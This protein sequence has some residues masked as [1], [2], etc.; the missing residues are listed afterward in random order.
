M[1]D[2]PG[3]TCRRRCGNMAAVAR[4]ERG[5]WGAR[6]ATALVVAVV[7]VVSTLPACDTQAT[8][9]GS[10]AVGRD[11]GAAG[12]GSGAAPRESEAVPSPGCE[13]PSSP[14][15]V[16]Q[17]RT[18]ETDGALRW[19]LVT[20]PSGPDG[21]LPLVLDF[22]GLSEGAELHSRTSGFSALAEEEGFV[23][24]YPQGTGA[25]P[26]WSVDAGGDNADARF[27]DALLSE[28]GR[29]LCIDLTRVYATGL[30]NGALL[31]SVLGC[32]RAATFAAIAPV[33]GIS[34]PQGCEPATPVPVVSYHGTADPILLF[35]GGVGSVLVELVNGRPVT[36]TEL[37]PAD[38]EGAGY[39]AAAE[40]WAVA[41]GCDGH[42]DEPMGESVL[43]RAYDCPEGA[44]TELW[45]VVGG[46]HSWPGSETFTGP[47]AGIF[48]PTT[49][50][51]DASRLTW[52]FFARHRRLPP[53]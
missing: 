49:D 14:P 33:A 21:P 5:R 25:L 44:D 32:S 28:L 35:N 10:G 1:T 29:I 36:P 9:E 39:P 7:V 51:I 53:T 18:L 15:V 38:L 41:N 23:V 17:K 13:L 3:G 6:T 22:H 52:E 4:R 20:V 43:H 27:V 24:A 12:R 30:S 37:P 42:T 31:T 48:G 26:G 46:G 50:E 16:E 47:L 8:P 40:A 11:S 2:G 19:Y 45:I 34:F